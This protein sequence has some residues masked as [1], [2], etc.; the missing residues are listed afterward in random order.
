MAEITLMV[1]DMRWSHGDS[2]ASFE[3]L[4]LCALDKLRNMSLY[5]IYIKKK[6]LKGRMGAYWIANK[7]QQK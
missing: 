5:L 4:V 3:R 6:A 1:Y 2:I 7:K